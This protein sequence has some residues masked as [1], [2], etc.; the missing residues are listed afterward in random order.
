M[1]AAGARGTNRLPRAFRLRRQRLIRPLF[2][3]QRT[4]VGTLSQGCIRLLYRIVSRQ[5]V[6]AN[7]PVQVGFAAGRQA[8][9]AVERNRIRRLLRETY[10]L[11][12]QPLL[13]LF[14]ARPDTLTLM[15]LYRAQPQEARER[16]SRDLPEALRRLVMQLQETLT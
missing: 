9:K 7:V 11:H 5:E 13:A 3:R 8:R 16:I 6:G 1:T 12:Q 4:D 10:R 14:H 2:D 15:I